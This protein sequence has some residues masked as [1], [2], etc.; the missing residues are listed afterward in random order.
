ML[1]SLFQPNIFPTRFMRP[2]KELE[3]VSP[4][5]CEEGFFSGLRRPKTFSRNNLNDS[6]CGARSLRKKVVSGAG[7]WFLFFI[8]SSLYQCDGLVLNIK[9]QFPFMR[10]CNAGR[11]LNTF[12]L[13]P[14]FILGIDFIDVH[15]HWIRT[16]C[17]DTSHESI[18]GWFTHFITN[19]W[20]RKRITK[21]LTCS[22]AST[23]SKKF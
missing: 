18:S 2:R 12:L 16:W 22:V 6:I 17:Q 11:I 7:N 13:L 1:E 10:L 20:R 19:F 14:M 23:N 15:F 9:Q 21:I 3:N 8:C 5:L 4:S